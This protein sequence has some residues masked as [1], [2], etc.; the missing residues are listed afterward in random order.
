MARTKSE[1]ETFE[2]AIKEYGKEQQMIVAIEE[3]SELQK[4]ICKIL[5]KNI[6]R[7]RSNVKVHEEIADCEIM[8]EQLKMIFKCDDNVEQW[9]LDKVVRL[10]TRLGL[11]P[12]VMKDE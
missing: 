4:E 8:L 9:R 1:Q 10:K 5:R 6:G 12:G 7:P 2:A 11:L 3:L